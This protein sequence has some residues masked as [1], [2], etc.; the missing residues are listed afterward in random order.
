MAS[1]QTAQWVS[2][3]P[4]VKLT[5]TQ[6]ASTNT[7]ATLS[8]TLQYIASSAASTNGVARSYTVK[9]AGT[10]VK[11]GTYNIN[12]VSGTKTIASGTKTVNKTTATQSIA[13]SV[14]F[15]FN[16]T[17]SGTYGGTKSASS[18]ISVAAKPS[19]T[20]SY[21]ANG[22][23]GAPSSQTK[24]Y[25]T[26]LT[27]SSTK[28]TRT[29][30]TFQGW[31]TS[32]SGSVAYASGASYTANAA[33]T[34]YAVWSAITYTVSYNANGGNGA[35]SN[36]TK[37]YGVT[38]TLS[39][40]KPT[41]TNY[42]FKGWGTSAS[43]T[44]VS[45]VAGSSY[46]A[47][48]AITLYA[49]WEL[50]YVKPRISNLSIVRSDSSGTAM[51]EGANALVTFDWE[52]DLTVSSITIEWKLPSETTWTSETVTASSTSGTTSHVI[53][54]DALDVELTYDIRIT[55]TDSGGSSYVTGS[56]TSMCFVID[57]LAGG[58]G[59]AFGKTAELEDTAEFEF[60][61]KFNNLVYGNAL[62]MNKLPE[63]PANSDLNNYMET[64]CY[65]VY[66][67]A[68]ASTIA[69]IPVERAG[70]LEVWSA[71]G[72][73]IRSEQ[74]SYL[75]QRY[76][77]YNIVNPTWERDITRSSDN[78]W[79]YGD[80]WPTTL[81]PAAAFKVY[82]KSAITICLN[83]NAVLGTVNT[84]TKIPFDTTILSTNGR[85]TLSSN[86]IRIGSAI[87]YVKV[88]GQILVKH[89]SVNGNRHARIQK[90]SSDTTTSISWTCIYGTATYNTLYILTPT[91]LSVEEGD[92]I[93]MVYYTGDAEDSIASG[94][95]SN[96]RQTYLT[97]EEL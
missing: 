54:S 53:G 55:V 45:Y 39:S 87:S 26:A 41:R 19:Y 49:V 47:N 56:L 27:L 76:I 95:S 38:L 42:I 89:G 16:V 68:N 7:D 93:Q 36:Q 90:I 30:Y 5:V 86:T 6:S 96:G 22:G 3:A 29:G 1:C 21:N 59:V 88:S 24:W 85:L 72:E 11:N 20:V 78:V 97:V 84:Y 94:S 66:K 8:W 37:T 50:S 46:T 80:W 2:T 81:S 52:C 48:A 69:N 61:A 32:A 57:A 67:N 15:A 62:G 73:G 60:D 75:R 51:D 92:L 10:T 77:P 70:R 12:G 64:G 91:I 4:Y 14:S 43:A 58:K 79:T 33:V 82:S 74:W 13:F 40:T 9:I 17:W 31:A 23:S 25:D 34:L 44:T 63:I 18:S 71:T 83:A 65:A 35:P 28:P